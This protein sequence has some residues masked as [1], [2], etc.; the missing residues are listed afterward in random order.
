VAPKKLSYNQIVNKALQ[1]LSQSGLNDPVQVAQWAERLRAAADGSFKPLNQ[2]KTDVTK[3]FTTIYNRATRPRKPPRVTKSAPQQT[4]IRRYDRS[5]LSK[6]AKLELDRRIVSSIA[7]IKLNR[8]ISA[9]SAAKTLIGW[10]SSI[11]PEGESHTKVPVSTVAKDLKRIP[12]EENRVIIDQGHKLVASLHDIVS[13]NSGAIAAIWHSHAHQI[14][15][16]SRPEHAARQDAIFIIRGS[17]ADKEGLIKPA[18]SPGYTDQV[19]APAE[20]PFCRCHYQY[21]FNL[22]DLPRSML[23]QKAIDFLS[24]KRAA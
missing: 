16:D 8:E 5:N 17:W 10:H 23:T 20:F 12:Y 19:E 3:Y 15:Y 11:T 6:E 22:Q 21:V 7:L 1:E 13:R 2:V 14:G 18:Q 24:N 9:A 4:I